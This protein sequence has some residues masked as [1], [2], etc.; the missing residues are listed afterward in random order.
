MDKKIFYSKTTG[1][2]YDTDVHAEDQIPADAIEISEAAHAALIESQCL[3]KT[4]VSDADGYPVAIDPPGP[5]SAELWAAR[6]KEA[7]TSLEESDITVLR[8]YENGVPVPKEWVAY[9]KALRFIVGAEDGD[10][11]APFPQQPDRPEGV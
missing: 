10:V 2:F 6:R 3:G 5:T 9:R 4:I 8:C 7:Q 11:S 1:G